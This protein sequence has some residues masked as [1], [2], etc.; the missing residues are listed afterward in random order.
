MVLAMTKS[1]VNSGQTIPAALHTGLG[2]LQRPSCWLWGNGIRYSGILEENTDSVWDF[3]ITETCLNTELNQAKQLGLELCSDTK[4]RRQLRLSPFH[5]WDFEVDAANQQVRFRL[6]SLQEEQMRLFPVP[7]NLAV[8]ITGPSIFGRTF[9]GQLEGLSP[10]EV[11]ASVDDPE[12]L[13]YPSA[14]VELEAYRPWQAVF[15]LNGQVVALERGE[16]LTKAYIRLVDQRSVEAAG[17]LAACECPEFGAHTMWA[18][19]LR[20]SA[21]KKAIRVEPVVTAE[22]MALA[23]ELRRDANRFY[24]RRIAANNLWLWSDELDETSLIILILLGNKPVGTVRLVVNG[25]DQNKSRI[26]H[27]IELPDFIRAGMF[28]EVSKLAIHPDFRGTGIRLPLFAEVARLA[29]LLDCRYVVFEA[30]EKLVPIFEKIGAIRLDLTKS[31]EGSDEIA[32]VMYFD[33]N[34]SAPSSK[35]KRFMI[36]T[37]GALLM[38]GALFTVASLSSKRRTRNRI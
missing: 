31:P 5:V 21:L 4:L 19:G 37:A 3:R 11:L 14:I 36:L 15:R 29:L 30:I 22:K 17:L 8:S 9:A 7:E 16:R 12:H 1:T 26:E 27:V 18:Y 24:G 34:R 35:K 38:A 20:L 33:L 25:E 28:V 13:L 2:S 6:T 23:L 32:H 10:Y